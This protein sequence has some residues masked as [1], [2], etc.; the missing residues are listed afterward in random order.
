MSA[1]PIAFSARIVIA[2]GF[3]CLAALPARSPAQESQQPHKVEIPPT[4]T[5]LEG[6][7]TVR[8]DSTQDATQRRVLS[9]TEATKQR[10]IVNVVDGR[11]YW[12]SR[13]NRPLQLS[14]A[15]EFTYLA[16]DP[17][18]YIRITRLDEKISYVEHVDM[19]SG[20]ITWWGELTIVVNK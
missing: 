10:L 9:T 14:S 7:P 1:D 15:G 4:V 18:K 13:E 12:S 19:A 3:L 5:T 16:S 17:G 20:S 11:F 8:I 2:I 6:V